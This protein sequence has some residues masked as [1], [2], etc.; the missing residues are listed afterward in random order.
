M[1]RERG[2]SG[3]FVAIP[4]VDGELELTAIGR[5]EV[6]VRVGVEGPEHLYDV[7]AIRFRVVDH[8]DRHIDGARQAVLVGGGHLDVHDRGVGEHQFDVVL[9]LEESRRN[10]AVDTDDVLDL[11]PGIVDGD[12]VRLVVVIIVDEDRTERV[13]RTLLANPESRAA[14]FARRLGKVGHVHGERLERL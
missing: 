9:Q 5:E 14:H 11:E 13:S 7:A 8:G 12:G 4:G 3:G 6:E 2:V 1:H 10:L